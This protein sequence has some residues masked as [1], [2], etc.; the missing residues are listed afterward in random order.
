MTM[1][2]DLLQ[3]ALPILVVC[4]GL[5]TLFVEA[6]KMMAGGKLKS[7]NIVAAIVGAIIGTV[8]PVGY[9]LYTGI[10]FGIQNILIILAIAVLSWLC[11][12]LGF[13]KVVQTLRQLK[14]NTEE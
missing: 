10:G 1:Q 14:G 7:A 6:I 2:N 5:T 11:S 8:I 9:I 3:V 12:M 4:S 13:D